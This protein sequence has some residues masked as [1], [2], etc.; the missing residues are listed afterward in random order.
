M[1]ILNSMTLI[2]SMMCRA[3]GQE[4]QKR[5]G[6]KSIVWCVTYVNIQILTTLMK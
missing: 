5:Y 6:D 1:G 3:P 4:L 2:G